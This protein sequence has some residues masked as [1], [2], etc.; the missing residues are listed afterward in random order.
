VP[1][2]VG[3]HNVTF[4]SLVAQTRGHDLLIEYPALPEP[5]DLGAPLLQELTLEGPRLKL[6]GLWPIVQYFLERYPEPDLLPMDCVQ[7][8]VARSIANT[9]LFN[10]ELDDA[11]RRVK[12]RGHFIVNPTAP[13]LIDLAFIAVT[14]PDDD[15]WGGLHRNVAR[16]I[17]HT[18][19][20]LE[21]ILQEA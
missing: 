14:E 9:I 7:R 10:G 15:R 5:F 18:R 16:F 8:A 17:D 2:G 11:L 21:Q 1:F 13:T 4:I 12:P 19:K 3:P 20:D 6:C